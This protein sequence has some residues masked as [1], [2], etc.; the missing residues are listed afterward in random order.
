MCFSKAIL[1]YNMMWC[2][3]HPMSYNEFLYDSLAYHRESI[4]GWRPCFP[5][6]AFL[7]ICLAWYYIFFFRSE[8]PCLAPRQLFFLITYLGI[9][10][11]S[12]L[13]WSNSVG[14]R[15]D[16]MLLPQLQ[17][18]IPNSQKVLQSGYCCLVEW[19]QSS[20]ISALFK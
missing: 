14:L 8:G 13:F 18:I 5:C 20:K 6:R 15:E 11:T 9:E 10:V 3:L 1:S 2:S 4:V 17:Q 19:S 12:R 7:S 16:F